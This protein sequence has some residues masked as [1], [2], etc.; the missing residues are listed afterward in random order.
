[1][2]HNIIKLLSI[3]DKNNYES[4]NDW[5]EL[6]LLLFN[7]DSSLLQEFVEFTDKLYN[8]ENKDCLNLWQNAKKDI[9]K[10]YT[11]CLVELVK[12][13]NHEGYIKYLANY[14]TEKYPS[15]K[16]A[17]G[18]FT[19]QRISRNMMDEIVYDIFGG[20]IFVCDNQWYKFD[21]HNWKMCESKDIYSY[22]VTLMQKLFAELQK[23]YGIYVDYLFMNNT[24]FS[25]KKFV[26][27][28]GFTEIFDTNTKLIGFRNGV[29]DLREQYFRI[30]YPSDY[31]YKTTG[32]DYIEF[33]SDYTGFQELNEFLKFVKNENEIKQFYEYAYTCLT[34]EN[35]SVDVWYGKLGKTTLAKL[36]CELLGDYSYSTNGFLCR[37]DIHLGYRE[38]LVKGCRLIVS[39]ENNNLHTKSPK[40]IN[41]IV[42][43][44]KFVDLMASTENFRKNYGTS[45][46]KS[47]DFYD[48]LYENDPY[49]KQIFCE[50]SK[51][52]FTISRRLYETPHIT[53]V[54]H[55][56]LLI[57]S[58][59]SYG[60]ELYNKTEFKSDIVFDPN[61]CDKINDSPRNFRQIFMWHLLN[62]INN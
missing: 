51:N 32:Y 46:V 41:R 15:L 22:V 1:M 62:R 17:C 19:P 18:S 38:S 21:L 2:N 11:S 14:I 12:R 53:P 10:S 9:Q 39:E 34:G 59:P 58:E 60:T 33:S 8:K 31:I 43:G 45:P 29:Y 5:R 24:C 56:I 36:L 52:K 37:K 54:H 16:E 48:I 7:I 4:H 25:N 20:T 49:G 28:S 44:S 26:C 50:D 30:G 42:A 61:A 3:L 55:N 47:S 27:R 57:D 35:R 6:G 40:A 13:D 23:L